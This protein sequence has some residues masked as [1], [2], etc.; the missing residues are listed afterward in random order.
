M[1]KGHIT[2]LTLIYAAEVKARGGLEIPIKSCDANFM[3][4]FGVGRLKQRLYITL[5]CYSIDGLWIV[6]QYVWN[7]LP[8]DKTTKVFQS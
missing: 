8:A 3:N 2:F 4:F 7:S 1:F 5:K 6:L